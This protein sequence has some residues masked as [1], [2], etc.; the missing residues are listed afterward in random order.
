[1]LLKE[2]DKE[3]ISQVLELILGWMNNFRPRT[4]M[5]TDVFVILAFDS[6]WSPM[7]YL[8]CSSVPSFY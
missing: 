3:H 7:A 4:T 5:A 1:M 2:K 6:A 8:K